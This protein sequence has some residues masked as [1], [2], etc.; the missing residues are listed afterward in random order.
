METLNENMAGKRGQMIVVGGAKG[1]VGKTILSVNLSVALA[2][3]SVK[4]CIIDGDFQ[5]G[6]VN[7]AMD[8][9]ETFTIKDA[10]EAIGTLDVINMSSYL[11][12]H[13]SGVNVLVA[14]DRP[15]YADMITDENLT[16]I[17]SL[18]LDIYDYVIVDTGVGFHENSLPFIERAD[19]L[20]L[21]TNLEMAT[22]KNTK[23]MKETLDMLGYSNKIEY[24]I[25]RSTMESVLNAENVAEILGTENPYLVPN[26]FKYVSQSFNM[27]TPIVSGRATN[28][29]AKAI[30]KMAEQIA[31]KRGPQRIKQKKRLFGIR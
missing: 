25:N 3:R 2:K 13:N 7:L 20:L 21:V 15:E 6:D 22:I 19:K 12:Q 11:T 28:V 27:G 10:I 17:T 9:Q 4:V 29:V 30:F 1:G 23:R 18:L 16:K 14:P 24:I 31:S 26:D 8:I 5:F